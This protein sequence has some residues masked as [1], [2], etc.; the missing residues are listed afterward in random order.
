MSSQSSWFVSIRGL[1]LWDICSGLLFPLIWQ[2]W[3]IFCMT[4]AALFKRRHS[5]LG[6]I[7]QI[8]LA[9]LFFYFLQNALFKKFQS[10]FIFCSEL[11]N[12]LFLN[13]R[14]YHLM[15]VGKIRIRLALSIFFL[16]LSIWWW[17]YWCCQGKYDLVNNYSSERSDF[18]NF[19]HKISMFIYM[20]K[21]WLKGG[22][23]EKYVV[24]SNNLFIWHLSPIQ[25]YHL[26]LSLHFK[27]IWNSFKKKYIAVF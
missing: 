7:L 23:S 15:I 18:Y 3:L 9:Y 27:I 6:C 21:I 26:Q 24:E 20:V 1:H 22:K 12:L 19:H 2:D 11:K 8:Y 17:T 16:Q 13:K 10:F 4:D 25:L 14:R 5:I